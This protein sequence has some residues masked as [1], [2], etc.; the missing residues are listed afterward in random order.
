MKIGFLGTG[1]IATAVVHGIAGDGHHICVSERNADKANH[2][3]ATYDNVMVATNQN[4]VDKSEVI[5]LGLMPEVAASILPSLSFKPGQIIIS[6]IAAL[7]LEQVGELVAPA[8]ARALMLPFPNI[9]YG[10]SVIPMIG[11]QAIVE[12]IFGAKNTLTVLKDQSEI[13]ALLCA[14]AVLSPAAKL[15][16]DAAIWLEQNGV[17]QGRGEPFLRMLVASNLTQT[18]ASQLL[19]ALNTPGGYNQR[20]RQHMDQE[21]VPTILAAGLDALKSSR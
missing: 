9:A 16:Q 21:G 3:A 18:P 2:L 19:A 10:G 8:Q 7:S 4:V 17:D 11:D 15:V 12:T 1:I 5:F 14:Q 20:L 6:F 13:D